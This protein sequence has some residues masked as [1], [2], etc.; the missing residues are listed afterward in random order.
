MIFWQDIYKKIELKTI[1]KV[2]KGCI[3]AGGK[4]YT[5]SSCLILQVGNEAKVYGRSGVM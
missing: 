5:T 1:V 2:L 4:S 3:F